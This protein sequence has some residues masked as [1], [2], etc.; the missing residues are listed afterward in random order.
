MSNKIIKI[1]SHPR[2]GTNYLG[3]LLKE[4]FYKDI[5]LSKEGGWG[6]W[7]NTIMFDEP[8][9]HG[10]LFGTHQGPTH[11]KARD[12]GV[13]IYR[14][15]RAVSLSVWKSFNFLNDEHKKLS[16]SK[17]LRT[18]LDWKNSPG[19]KSR[20]RETV[21]EQWYRHVNEW[22]KE[23][24]RRDDLSLI[25]YEDLMK[26]PKKA[27]DKLAEERGLQYT[28]GFKPLT[29]MVGPSPNAGKSL[30]W[31]EYFSKK[32]E[33]YIYTIVPEDCRFLWNEG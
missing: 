18:K 29:K 6:H 7:S 8:V 11:R 1:Y 4:N 28:K 30:A 10:V 19:Y 22:A 21:V 2:S 31:K 25:R 12:S 26:N 32:D 13:Y 14:D 20:P 15:V 23:A 16:F 9:E 33:E 5:D 24:R 27:L 17:F 3:A